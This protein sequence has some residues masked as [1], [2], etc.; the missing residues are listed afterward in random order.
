MALNFVNEIIRSI[1]PAAIERIAAALGI[2]GALAQKAIAIAIPAILATLGQKAATPGGAQELYRAVNTADP[3]IFSKLGSTLTGARSEQYMEGGAS[4]LS[5]MIGSGMT[6]NIGDAI[7]K[8][9]GLSGTAGTSLLSI[10]AP[11]VLGALAKNN[12]GSDATGLSTLLRSQQANIQSALPAGLGGLLSNTGVFRGG[13]DYQSGEAV[14]DVGR[15]ASTS[16][17]R[18]ARTT[19]SMSWLMWLIPLVLIA[20]GVWYFLANRSPPIVTTGETTTTTP[21]DTDTTIDGVDVGKQVTTVLDTV[22]SSLGGITDVA[23]AQ[24]ALP[25][26][27]E[28]V[29]ALDGV[30]GMAGKLSA[31]QKSTLVGLIAA[32]LPTLRDTATKVLA[33]PGVSEVAKPVVDSLIAKLEILAKST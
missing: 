1:T 32:S 21:A 13:S 31:A 28:A 9:T 4:A 30:S 6:S 12:A 15:T 11:M 8:S 14:V 23:S 7:A 2:N 10:A 17:P 3:D 18:P 24:A 29:T 25:K 33:I 19:S 27:Q 16:I 22:K 20:A 5:S 26:L